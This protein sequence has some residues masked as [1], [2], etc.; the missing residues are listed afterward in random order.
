M[1]RPAAFIGWDI[2]HHPEPKDTLQ[3]TWEAFPLFLRRT[4]WGSLRLEYGRP[5]ST[6]YG[7][8]EELGQK[9]AEYEASVTRPDKPPLENLSELVLR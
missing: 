4:W 6:W 5:V 9:M 3:D 2:K 8:R 1:S 7:T